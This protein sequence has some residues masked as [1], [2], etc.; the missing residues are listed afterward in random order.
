VNQNVSSVATFYLQLA[1][2]RTIQTNKTEQRKVIRVKHAISE[3]F[4]CKRMWKPFFT[5]VLE[6]YRDIIYIKGISMTSFLPRNTKDFECVFF[7]HTM[8]ISGVQS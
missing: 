5:F 2:L 3:R 8:K 6:N 4:Y 7:F 1:K